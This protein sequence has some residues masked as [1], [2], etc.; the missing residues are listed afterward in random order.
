MFYHPYF[1]AVSAAVLT[2]LT[3]CKPKVPAQTQATRV[4]AFQ[5]RQK[6]EAIKTYNAL[7]TK[8]P[9]SEWA[10]QAQERLKVLGPLPAATPAKKQ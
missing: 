3:A 8:Y 2:G 10:A 7:V 5:N 4:Q 6:I 9:D 1:I